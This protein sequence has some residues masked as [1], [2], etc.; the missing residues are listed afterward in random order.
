MVTRAAAGCQPAAARQPVDTGGRQPDA[1]TAPRHGRRPSIVPLQ[2]L[3]LFGLTGPRET[4]ESCG[5]GCLSCWPCT[6]LPSSELLLIT[7]YNVLV[8]TLWPTPLLT[9]HDHAV[10]RT[11]Y[12]AV[13]FKLPE[14]KWIIPI[15]DKILTTLSLPYIFS[16]KTL[17][18]K[19]PKEHVNYSF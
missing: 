17:G 8:Y 6:Y 16:Q 10:V 13:V 2:V 7:S 19:A 15:N 3:R 4:P 18:F 5:I 11:S 12:T 14:S 1:P 9:F